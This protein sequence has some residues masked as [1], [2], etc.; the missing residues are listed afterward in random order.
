MKNEY[1]PQFPTLFREL[2]QEYNLTQKDISEK[3][4]LHKTYISQLANGLRKPSIETLL[5]ISDALSTKEKSRIEI[6]CKMLRWLREDIRN[7]GRA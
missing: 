6:Y 7:G 5:K 4:E 1:K 3:T 2:L